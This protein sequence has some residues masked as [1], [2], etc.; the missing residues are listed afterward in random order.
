MGTTGVGPS[1]RGMGPSSSLLLTNQG[2]VKYRDFNSG[3][4]I[5]GGDDDSWGGQPNASFSVRRNVQPLMTIENDN[6]QFQPSRRRLNTNVSQQISLAGSAADQWERVQEIVRDDEEFK[7]ISKTERRHISSGAWK[8]PS[9]KGPNREWFIT[10]FA[11]FCKRKTADVVEDFAS[12][13]TFAVVTFTSRQAAIAARHCLADGRGTQRWTPVEDIP[14]PP[15]ADA[16]AGDFKTC[17][18][19]CRP[20]TLTVNANQQFVRKYAALLI[21]AVMYIFYT[22]PLTFVAALVTPEKLDKIFP[23]IAEQAVDNPFLNRILSGI[24]PAFL[25]SM[26]FALCPVIFKA[27]S[28]FGSNAI[29]V[30]QAEYIAL[31]VNICTFSYAHLSL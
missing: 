7:G 17:R 16:A 9:M 24:V 5:E 4:E 28:N 19:C 25:N 27:I 30:N 6:N 12:E 14:V 1:T 21:L 10:K 23:G 13:S 11:N 18:G 15:L 26:F 22:I 8:V 2:K 3:W 29:S 20:V 31:Q